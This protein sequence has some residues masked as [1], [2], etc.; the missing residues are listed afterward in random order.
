MTLISLECFASDKSPEVFLNF[1]N[2]SVMPVLNFEKI[3]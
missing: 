2:C 1:N 3:T